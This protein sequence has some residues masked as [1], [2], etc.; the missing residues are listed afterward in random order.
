MSVSFMRRNGGFSLI[1]VLVAVLVLS[2]GMLGV[3]LVLVTTHKANTSS[4]IRQNAQQYAT[5]MIARMRSNPSQSIGGAYDIAAN[6]PPP[7]TYPDNCSATACTQS[8]LAKEDVGQW[9][10]NLS[11][12]LTDGT[13]TVTVTTV[14]GNPEATVTVS[15]NDAPAMQAFKEKNPGMTTYTLKTVL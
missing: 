2:L 5:D 8:Q 3:A 7:A 6:T 4:Y 9:L 15:W 10:Y 1:E 13:G 14:N 12:N 11:K